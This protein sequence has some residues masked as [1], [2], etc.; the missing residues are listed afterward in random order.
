MLQ[1][2]FSIIISLVISISAGAQGTCIIN[3][4][5][6]DSKL[7][8]GSKSKAVSLM[9][10]DENGQKTEVAVA[11]V[12]KGEYTFKYELSKNEPVLMY[13][14]AGFG[15]DNDIELFIEA[16]E[17]T[18]STPSAAEPC[19]STVT[20][21]PTN[22]TYTE[23]KA[24]LNNRENEIATMVK[25][26]VNT[27]GHN[28]EAIKE[29][30]A[31]ESIKTRSQ[32]IR[33]LIDHNT[34]PMT[35]FEIEHTLLPI[36]S[37]AYA[38]QIVKSVSTT[39]H[40]HPYYHSLRNKV[41]ANDMK[42]GNELP[43]ITLPMLDGE[44]KNLNDFRGKYVILNFWSSDCAKSASMITELQHLYEVI[45]GKEEYV[46]ISFSLDNDTAA[47]KEAVNSKGIKHEVWLH[48]SDGAGMASPAAK[49]YK[50][51]KTPKIILVE[52]EGRAVSLNMDIDE[53]VMRI[54]QIMSGDL[55]YLD[56]KEE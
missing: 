25:E 31:R 50:V 24:I 26:L 41:L 28:E 11:K 3:G 48:A 23:Y 17:I 2:L 13:T 47:W 16:G 33:F 19:M 49:T 37:T 54:E 14:I 39:L 18:V 46:I 5:I 22:D 10:A 32:I 35:P 38:D 36:L 30:Q 40:S 9:R 34:S 43:D 45:K 55:Y 21:T 20:G 52:P 15:E 6:A 44:K 8:D 1:K 51:E 4:N 53:V 27:A 7:A 29:L 56:Q 42:V 12:K